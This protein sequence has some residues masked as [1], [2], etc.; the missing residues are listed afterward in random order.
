[1]ETNLE[2]STPKP[3]GL[4]MRVGR[5]Q[6]VY[7]EGDTTGG[8]FRLREG[9]VRVTKLSPGGRTITVRHVLPGDFF[10]EEAL[11]ASQH[12]TEAEALTDVSLE[13]LPPAI[14]DPTVLIHVSRNLSEQLA[15]TQRFS[16]HLQLGELPERLARYLLELMDTPLLERD[17]EGR[18]CFRVAHEFLAQGVNATREST[19]KM[20]LEMRHRGLI[21]TSYK[22]VTL[23][24]M[25]A[26]ERLANKELS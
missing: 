4:F 26:L 13:A 21:L 17:T 18:P 15:R 12:H 9:M 7:F 2:T 8:L 20:L 5:G 25:I 14:T 24:D 19:S 10:G 11:N 3:I 6:P 23:V 16:A 22:R 1:M